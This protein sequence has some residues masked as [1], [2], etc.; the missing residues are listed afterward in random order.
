MWL[1]VSSESFILIIIFPV[2]SIA[3][4]DVGAIFSITNFVLLTN[5]VL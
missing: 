3:T 5:N 4:T 1:E 2:A